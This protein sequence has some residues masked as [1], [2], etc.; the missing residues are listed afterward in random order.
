MSVPEH[1]G[2][3]HDQSARVAVHT[4][5]A[6]RRGAPR[7]AYV[8]NDDPEVTEVLARLQRAVTRPYVPGPS[9]ARSTPPGMPPDMDMT[10]PLELVASVKRDIEHDLHA[11]FAD[12]HVTGEWFVADDEMLSTLREVVL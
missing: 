4:L 6:S 8:S 3:A 1:P 10:A 7:W 2:P 12:R 5:S 11:R 9:V